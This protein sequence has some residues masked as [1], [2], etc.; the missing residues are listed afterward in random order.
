MPIYSH[1]Q[2]LKWIN[3]S[4][5]NNNNSPTFISP[6]LQLRKLRLRFCSPEGWDCSSVQSHS[7][8]GHSKEPAKLGINSRLLTL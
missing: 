1:S 8:T 5:N 2:L 3:N 4:P 6:R 7:P